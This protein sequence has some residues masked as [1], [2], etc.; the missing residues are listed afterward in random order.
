MGRR[1]RQWQPAPARTVWRVQVR[2]SRLNKHSSVDFHIGAQDIVDIITESISRLG[3]S[4]KVGAKG[5]MDCKG[6][7]N[8][9]DVEWGLY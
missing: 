3:G 2:Y 5:R 8:S 6:N 7:L 4:G 9:Q 1:E